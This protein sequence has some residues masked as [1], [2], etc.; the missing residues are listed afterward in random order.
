METLADFFKA[1]EDRFEAVARNTIFIL[2]LII[3][4]MAFIALLYGLLFLAVIMFA[5]AVWGINMWQD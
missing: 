3:G 4:F 5:H 1:H 2:C